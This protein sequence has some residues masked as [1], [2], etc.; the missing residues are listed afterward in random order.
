M[1]MR[2]TPQMKARQVMG[3]EFLD[4]FFILPYQKEFYFNLHYLFFE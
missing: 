3:L 2:I 1:G 4:E